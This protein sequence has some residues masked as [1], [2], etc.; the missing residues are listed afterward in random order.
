MP[1][2]VERRLCGVAPGVAAFGQIENGIHDAPPVCGRAAAWRR[3]GKHRLK[4]VPLGIGEAGVMYSVFHV[5]TEAALKFKRLE[6]QATHVTGHSRCSNVSL[7]R[8]GTGTADLLKQNSDL[9]SDLK[10]AT[11]P[12]GRK[13]SVARCYHSLFGRRQ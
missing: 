5:P 3:F 9:N 12:P 2:K 6:H 4:E 7:G 1:A 10:C 8:P 11:S 13:R